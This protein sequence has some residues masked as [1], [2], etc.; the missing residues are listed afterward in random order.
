MAMIVFLAVSYGAYDAYGTVTFVTYYD[1]YA[2]V[3]NAYVAGV[4]CVPTFG[5][6][7]HTRFLGRRVCSGIQSHT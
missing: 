1:T 5:L 6:P 7:M 3:H 2:N 4:T